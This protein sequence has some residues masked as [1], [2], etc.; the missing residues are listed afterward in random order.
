M[1]IKLTEEH[2][3]VQGAARE[4]A[5]TVCKPGVIQRDTRMQYPYDE[6]KQMAE[7]GFRYALVCARYGG[8]LKSR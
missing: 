3:S 1:N 7:L 2:I 6:V 5:R 4:F 8:N